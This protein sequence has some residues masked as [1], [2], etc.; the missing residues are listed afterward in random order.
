VATLAHL[1]TI[2]R[3]A[4][5]RYHVLPLQGGA[6]ALITQRGAR[7]LGLFPTPDAENLLWTNSAAFDTVDGFKQFVEAGNWNLGGERVWIAPEIQYNV[8]DRNDFW[9]TLSV[10]PQMDPGE[11]TFQVLGFHDEFVNQATRYEAV[12]LSASIELTA[13]NIGK[14]VQ[15]LSIRR[16]IEPV[17]NP[18]KNLSHVSNSTVQYFGYRQSVSLMGQDIDT[19][20]EAWN[21]V[22]LNAGGQLIIPCMPFLEASDYFG[23]V[24]DETRTVHHGDVPH[25]KLNINGKQQYKIGYK[26]VSMTGRMAY[27]HR[28]P[29]GR[30]YLLIRSFFNNPSNVY[31]EEPPHLPGV[32]GH[33]VHVYNDGGEFGG[34][35]GFGEME[36]TGQTA[37]GGNENRDI[38]QD[39]FLMW[40]YIGAPESIRQVA[41]LLLGV[42]L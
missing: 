4:G 17:R 7:V 41:H 14:G 33:S 38:V 40:V 19:Y 27:H 42:R 35:N 36:C 10:P 6:K 3:E 20:S 24:P 11:Y 15:A 21:L 12:F 39:N 34:E 16:N 9:G 30:E 5:E 2:L 8:R 22:Q 18:L 37:E 13:Y 25:L 29:D 26:S 28:L 23:T 32:N 1:E 31:A